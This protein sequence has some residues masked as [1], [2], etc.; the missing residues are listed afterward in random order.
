MML[1]KKILFLQKDFFL[2]LKEFNENRDRYYFSGKVMTK[3]AKLFG[4]TAKNLEK[5][6]YDFPHFKKFYYKFTNPMLIKINV[7]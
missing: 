2:G 4:I 3:K 7:F 6:L 1:V 5:C